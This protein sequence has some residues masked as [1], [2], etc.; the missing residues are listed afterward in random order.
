MRCR[1]GPRRPRLGR[2]IRAVPRR[3]AASRP[4]GVAVQVHPAAAVTA[5]GA[6]ALRL[7]RPVGV[8]QAQRQQ[9]A[10]ADA[11]QRHG[12]GMVAQAPSECLR[13]IH[14]AASQI[15]CLRCTT[16]KGNAA[17]RLARVNVC[18]SD[19]AA[20]RRAATARA[21]PPPARSGSPPRQ[22]GGRTRPAPRVRSPPWLRARSARSRRPRTRWPVPARHR[23]RHSAPWL[24]LD[25]AWGRPVRTPHTPS[26]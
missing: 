1:L 15:P 19:R 3:G 25:D 21:A 26:L 10:E 4:V 9:P 16:K 13:Y 23:S 5:G 6:C 8:S 12:D 7:S 11:D 2:E 22:A 17:V 18:H 20:G 24:S 14:V